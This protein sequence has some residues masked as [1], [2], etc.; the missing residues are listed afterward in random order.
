[1]SDLSELYQGVILDHNRSPRNFGPLPDASAE[2]EGYN[3]LCGD[4]FTVRVKMDGDRIESVRFEGMGCA[5]SKASASVMTTLVKGKTREE[6]QAMFGR[7]QQMVT[8][9]GTGA[10]AGPAG[11]KLAVFSG[12]SE[13]P[14]RVKCAILGWHALRAAIEDRA[15]APVSTE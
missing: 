5:I 4:R 2:A 8:G 12:V 7:F 3:P 1:M 14:S 9:Q 11:R 15:S 13:F 6:A 10:V